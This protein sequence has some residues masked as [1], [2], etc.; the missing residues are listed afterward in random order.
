MPIR[1]RAP[2]LIAGSAPRLQRFDH[3]AAELALAI[4]AE[5]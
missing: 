4:R 5:T 2:S 3:G 1:R